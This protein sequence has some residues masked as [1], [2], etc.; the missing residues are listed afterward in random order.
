MRTLLE[1]AK[2]IY[3]GNQTYE[4]YEAKLTL[5]MIDIDTWTMQFNDYDEELGDDDLE[6]CYGEIEYFDDEELMS[7]LY[8]LIKNYSL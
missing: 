7:F 2:F 1:K 5:R 4:Q 3:V 8:D 6:L